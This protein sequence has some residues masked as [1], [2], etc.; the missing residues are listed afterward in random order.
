LRSDAIWVGL[1]AYLALAKILSDALVPITF[2]GEG[3]ASFF[4]RSSVIS[5]GLL[6]SVGIF[7]A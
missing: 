1:I 2:R 4:S 3:Q 6:G 7:C 5:Y